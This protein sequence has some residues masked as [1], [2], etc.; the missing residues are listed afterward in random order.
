M[1]IKFCC[2][3]CEQECDTQFTIA[4]YIVEKIVARKNRAT[5]LERKMIYEKNKIRKK[6]II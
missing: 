6:W 1:L 2:L 5:E 3:V 4:K